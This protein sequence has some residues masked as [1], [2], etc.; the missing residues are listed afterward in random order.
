M[1]LLEVGE[2]VGGRQLAVDEQVAHLEEGRVLGQL[3][4]R[5]AAVA[6]DAGVAVDV[7]DLR[8]AGRGVGEARSRR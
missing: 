8:R 2:L 7:G 6:Q 5:V 1:L 3:V 4:D